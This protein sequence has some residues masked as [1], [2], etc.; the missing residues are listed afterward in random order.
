M[1]S[2]FA[3]Q[4]RPAVAAPLAQRRRA[5]FRQLADWSLQVPLL[6]RDIL[7][8]LS[9]AAR[10]AL[11]RRFAASDPNASPSEPNILRLIAEKVRRGVEH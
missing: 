8:P 5:R 9:Q 3:L 4:D 2:I 6:R 11:G 10:P 1:P 7:Q